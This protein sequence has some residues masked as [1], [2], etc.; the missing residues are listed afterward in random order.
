MEMGIR[1]LSGPVSSDRH[2]NRHYFIIENKQYTKDD[3]IAAIKISNVGK[4]LNEQ[5]IS[6]SRLIII[7]HGEEIKEELNIMHFANVLSCLFE[8]DVTEDMGIINNKD[9]FMEDRLVALNRI[10]PEFCQST[11]PDQLKNPLFAE[12]IKEYSTAQGYS[13]AFNLAEQGNTEAFNYWVGTNGGIGSIG[14]IASED[15]KTFLIRCANVASPPLMPAPL[16]SY[17]NPVLNSLLS[18]EAIQTSLTTG[19][20]LAFNVPDSE[21][22]F[23]QKALFIFSQFFMEPKK[24]LLARVTFIGECTDFLNKFP[25]I[26]LK[27][28]QD[29][30]RIYLKYDNLASLFDETLS[31]GWRIHDLQL[32]TVTASAVAATAMAFG[33]AASVPAAP[34]AGSASLSNDD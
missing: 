6:L 29:F 25:A 18:V 9:L 27:E 23:R 8:K 15:L 24:D 11:T 3:L 4:F 20:A 31:I 21:T 26:S 7:Q 12:L 5:G 28:V 22:D 14:S 17:S 1:F 2:K 10:L 19:A 16:T 30:G 32:P 13:F 33:T 34:G